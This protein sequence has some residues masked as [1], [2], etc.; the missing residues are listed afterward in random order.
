MSRSVLF[1]SVLFPRPDGPVPSL[2][3]ERSA[4]A[5][6][7]E[8]IPVVH[9]PDSPLVLGLLGMDLKVLPKPA[10]ADV[11]ATVRTD[12]GQPV[13]ESLPTLD[14]LVRRLDI[15]CY[16]IKLHGCHDEV[17]WD[18]ARDAQ[19]A[20]QLVALQLPLI[21]GSFSHLSFLLSAACASR[22]GGA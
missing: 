11:F 1:C 19:P 7:P 5:D 2:E 13:T 18:G 15:I 9:P 22:V 4:C 21:S 6:P 10:S 20:A 16:A 12:E 14:A 17:C 3:T 8:L